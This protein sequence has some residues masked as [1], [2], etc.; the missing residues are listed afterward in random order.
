MTVSTAE[1]D[2]PLPPASVVL[3]HYQARPLL[4]ARRQGRSELEISPDLGR[5]TVAVRLD[6]AGVAF[7]G[8]GRLPWA[9]VERIAASETK[10]FLVEDGAATEIQ[11]FSEAT[12]WVRTLYP[13]A[14]APTML[15]SGLPM[16]RIKDTDP[17]RDTLNKVRTIA[18]LIGRVLDTATGL[19][20]TAIEAARTADEVVTIELDPAGLAVARLNPWSRDLFANPRIRQIVGDAVEVLPTFEA[21]S[22]TRIIHDPPMFALAGE[23]YSGD[24]YAELVRVLRRGGRLFHYIG[25]PAS[26][27]GARTTQGVIRRLEAA[28]FERVVRRPE[29]FGVTAVKR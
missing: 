22:F 10:C 28:G 3:S 18:P 19:G 6:A 26:K 5:S 13:T 2:L 17:Y 7:P 16:H 23:L 11:A 1:P 21:E 14:G 9:E 12:G 27:S 8:G 20:Y 29:A 25:D 15:V 24:F 4:D